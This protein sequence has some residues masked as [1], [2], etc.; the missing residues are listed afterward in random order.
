MLV[1]P[2]RVR[3]RIFVAGLPG[4]GGFDVSLV[5]HEGRYRIKEM[6]I[7]APDDGWLDYEHVRAA[8]LASYLRAGLAH[9]VTVVD[10][11]TGRRYS[12]DEPMPAPNPLWPTALVYVTAAAI[13]Q[14]P[15]RAIAERLGISRGDASRKVA[16]A[17]EAGFIGPT[18][19]GKAAF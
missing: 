1:A 4:L 16:A 19:Q 10:P 8:K 12:A 14:P 7:T 18:T 3:V 17:R 2:D 11:D 15:I 9:T 5:L 13:G 6:V